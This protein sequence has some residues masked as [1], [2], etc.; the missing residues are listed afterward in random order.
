MKYKIRLLQL[1]DLSNDSFYKSLSAL[2]MV[3]KMPSEEAEK[4][5][6]SCQFLGIETYVAVYAEEIIGTIRLLFEP[7]FYHQGRLA[8]HIEDVSVRLDYQGKGIGG[9][10]VQHAIK[11]CRDKNCYKVILNCNDSLVS[12]YEKQGFI[13]YDHG[14]R[15]NL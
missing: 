10:L 2:S 7:K 11:R 1:E 9:D 3:E 13:N 8:A 4:I 5:F 6:N 15:Y 14:L 12:F